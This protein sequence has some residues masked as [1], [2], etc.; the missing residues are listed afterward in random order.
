MFSAMVKKELILVMRDKHALLA[1]FIMPAI[2]ILIMSVAL[3]DQFAQ[4]KIVFDIN[5]IDND[6]SS[7]SKKLIESIKE[8]SNFKIVESKNAQF[9]ITIPKNYEKDSKT[10]IVISVKSSIKSDLLEIF[11][12]K[13][14]QTVLDQKIK[15]FKSAIEDF[16]PEASDFITNL[17]TDPNLLFTV[18]YQKSDKVPNATQQSVPTWI[19]FGMF[20]VIIPMS[21]IY[22]NERKQNT[23][24]RLN[25][26][27]VPVVLMAISK[28]I[29]YLIINQ[30]QAWIMIAVGIFLVP[31]FNTPAL[32]INGTISAVVLLSFS[33]SLSA[34]GVSSL[35]AVSASSSEQATTIGGILNILLGAIGGVMIPKFI[36]PESMQKL[37]D[38]SPMSWGLDG[39]L[40]IFLQAGDVTAVADESL[41]LALFGI[42][43]LILSIVIL[44][45][46]INKGL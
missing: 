43:T 38:I 28:S 2:F 39:F 44:K 24:A 35:I 5:I 1:L 34:I 45:L 4:D 29:P 31:Y 33:L 16:M 3:R 40:D 21:T 17:K 26:M 20:F 7:V 42:T 12:A 15:N 30:L 27:N 22:I 46:R 36:M 6:K 8:K 41:R 9:L 14:L 18:K 23:L 25:S 10:K 11:K 13:L 37:A 19:V 32:E